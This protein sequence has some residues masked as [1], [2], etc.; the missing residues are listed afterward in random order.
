MYVYDV[1]RMVHDMW[2]YSLVSLLFAGLLSAADLSKRDAMGCSCLHR[3]AR[4]GIPEVV[5]SIVKLGTFAAED[6]M[7]PRA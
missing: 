2:V 6:F 3:A 7:A 5:C 4:T 1:C